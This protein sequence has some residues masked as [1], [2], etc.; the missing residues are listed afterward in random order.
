MLKETER[1]LSLYRAIM[2]TV[3]A[4]RKQLLQWFHVPWF[5]DLRTPLE[6]SM[7]LIPWRHS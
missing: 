1:E 5:E 2:A 4:F 7:G 6:I 3:R